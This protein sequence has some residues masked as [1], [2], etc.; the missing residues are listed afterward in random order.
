MLAV[1]AGD[2]YVWLLLPPKRSALE[3]IAAR[4]VYATESNGS[5][6]N[7]NSNVLDEQGEVLGQ[8]K[9]SDDIAGSRELQALLTEQAEQ[10][11]DV[12]IAIETERA[13]S[14]ERPTK[15]NSIAF[16]SDR[17]ER[18]MWSQIPCC[19]PNPQRGNRQL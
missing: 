1:S 10:P 8:R 4:H 16:P 17:D 7:Y 14:R 2:L 9:I 5:N 12:V 15:T 18:E 11:E 3:A 13:N 19:G 6:S